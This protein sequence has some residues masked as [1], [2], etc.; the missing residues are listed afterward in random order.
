MSADR[1]INW[2]DHSSRSIA[3]RFPQ[4][5]G[6]ADYVTERLGALL[7]ET[8][9]SEI[10][11]EI[12]GLLPP[13]LGEHSWP[14]RASVQSAY[15]G[16]RKIGY[17]DF[18]QRARIA[19]TCSEMN[20]PPVAMGEFAQAVTDLF[21]WTVCREIPPGTKS[22]MTAVLPQDLRARMDLFSAVSDESRVA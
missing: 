12:L 1:V 22:R 7:L 2:F 4:V 9:P 10:S 18:I 20:L 15:R 11:R 19:L 6:C 8:L 3:A 14:L 13:T 17:P 5:A 16:R 21:L